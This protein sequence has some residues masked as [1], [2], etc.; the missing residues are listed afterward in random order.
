VVSAARPKIA[1]YP[2]TTLTP[3]LG[4]VSLSESRS[5]VMA[6]IPGIIDGA[7][8]GRGLG[9]QFLQHVERTRVLAYL[10]PLDAPDPQGTYDMLRHE[11]TAYSSTVAGKPHVVVLTK[12]DLVPTGERPPGVRAP[13]ALAVLP[14]SAI[15]H[16]GLKELTETLWGAVRDAVTGEPATES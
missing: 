11:A 4:V 13:A 3:N 10:V 5:F 2:F 16:S 7:H 1:D 9:D 15:A 6:D 14:I 8:A 12:A